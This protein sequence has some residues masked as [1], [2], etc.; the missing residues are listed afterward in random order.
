M[1]YLKICSECKEKNKPVIFLNEIN[2]KS[3]IIDLKLKHLKSHKNK[4]YNFRCKRS[5]NRLSRHSHPISISVK[6]WYDK[7][8]DG[9]ILQ[10]R[11]FLW[12]DNLFCLVAATFRR[13]F[14]RYRH[15]VW[16]FVSLKA[17]T[18]KRTEIIYFL[19]ILWYYTRTAVLYKYDK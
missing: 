3:F 5:Q 9:N 6:Q 19:P 18:T 12:I 15:R 4:E 13:R 8:R 11:Y 14:D 10:N 2:N 17:C 7:P 16:C 1:I